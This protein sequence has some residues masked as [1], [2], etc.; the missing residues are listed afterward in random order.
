MIL[1][2]SWVTLLALTVT[3]QTSNDREN[4]LCHLIFGERDRKRKEVF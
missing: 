1:I 2:I 4:D 3:T